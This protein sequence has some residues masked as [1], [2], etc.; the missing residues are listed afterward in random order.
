MKKKNT[1]PTLIVDN[2]K[3][4][5]IE[6]ASEFEVIENQIMHE[7]LTNGPSSPRIAEL[8]AQQSTA[9]KRVLGK[10][11]Q[12]PRKPWARSRARFKLIHRR[13]SG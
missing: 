7:K 1:I 3:T 2:D 8:R 5:L 10:L 13:T 12:K 11:A 4:F 9:L 6:V